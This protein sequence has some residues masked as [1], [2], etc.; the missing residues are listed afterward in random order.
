MFCSKCGQSLADTARFCPSCG[1]PVEPQAAAQEDP[2][3]Y[4]YEDHYAGE[5]DDFG[6]ARAGDYGD[7]RWEPVNSADT[8]RGTYDR[9]DRAMNE[10]LRRDREAQAPKG[11][12]IAAMVLGII[13]LV[14]VWVPVLPIILGLIGLI[15]GGVGRRK[16]ERGFSTV[17]IT[18]SLLGLVFGAVITLLWVRFI[19]GIVTNIDIND[20]SSFSDFDI[21]IPGII[22]GFGGNGSGGIS[23]GGIPGV[24]NIR[25][26]F[27]L[28]GAVRRLLQSLI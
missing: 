13:A 22:N 27:D 7:G 25:V 16:G 1:A 2:A 17:G 11:A 12:S 4:G 26:S 6:G 15:C 20:I 23:G 28:A 19:Y 8:G 9:N 21:D 10:R 3:G 18:L 24:K 5:E 14:L